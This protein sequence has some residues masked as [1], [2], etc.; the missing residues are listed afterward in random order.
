MAR[1]AARVGILSVFHETNTFSPLL[2]V[3]PQRWFVGAELEGGFRGT[4]SVVGGMIDGAAASGY[5]VVPIFGALAIPAGLI[6]R[7]AADEIRAAVAVGLEAAGRLDG[8]L[9]ELHGALVAEGADDYEEDIVRLLRSTRPG[10]PIAA[11]T[12]YHA[13]VATP[14][15]GDL[16]LHLGYLTN[17]HVDI[18]ERGYKAA[19]L[20]G[21]L[22]AGDIDPVRVHRGVGIVAAPVAQADASEPMHSLLKRAAEFEADGPGLLDVTVHAGYAYADVPHLGMGFSA[23]A[24]R[25][26]AGSLGAAT[27][28]VTQL[29]EMAVELREGFTRSMPTATEAARIV[30]V[31]GAGMDRPIALI[32]TGD[33][34]NGGSPGDGTW[35]LRAVAED[36]QFVR[37]TLIYVCDPE[38]VGSLW[39]ARP[40][41]SARVS[42]GGWTGDGSGGPLPLDLTVVS[43][44]DGVFHN[45]GPMST[46]LRVNMGRTLVLR[47]GAMDAVV[48]EAAI[49]PNDPELFRS[50]GLEPSEYELIILKGAAAVRA[51]WQPIVGSFIDVATPGVTDSDVKRLVYRRARRPLW[52][53]DDKPYVTDETIHDPHRRPLPS[54]AEPPPDQR[55]DGGER[56]PA[57]P[58]PKSPML[59]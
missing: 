53:L 27:R 7:V 36:G 15:L 50:Q 51:A 56:P 49:Q 20:L 13:N 6:P 17:P 39:T 5:E 11:V 47:S 12:D 38:L 57:E 3:H 33:N 29:A 21:R 4:S 40:G 22:L 26:M 46:G 37:R 32:D 31:D 41:V 2:T 16:D 28:A 43:R 18:A 9:L 52:P 30:V 25:Y 23:T 24:D 55:V 35:L 44:S 34:I 10:I 19:Q 54:P 58:L 59:E 48:S 1:T 8:I 14:R 45:R 42:V